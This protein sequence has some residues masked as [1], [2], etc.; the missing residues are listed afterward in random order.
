MKILAL[1]LGIII[2]H[3]PIEVLGGT[4]Y[5]E[6]TGHGKRIN[7]GLA[8]FVPNRTHIKDAA[9]A[10]DV[11]AVV[12][13]DLLF[14]RAFNLIEGGPAPLRGTVLFDIWK[15]QGAEVLVAAKVGRRIDNKCVL[16]GIIYNVSDG[17]I[18]FE[19]QLIEKSD[20]HRQLA[21]RWA[22]EVIMHFL[23]K[24]GVASSK[25][26][27]VNDMSG[28]KELYVVDYDGEN[29]KKITD[30]KSIVLFPEIS[31]DGQKILF[32][33][34]SAGRQILYLINPD[35][36]KRKTIS[37][38]RG[39]NSA[40][41]WS[42]DGQ[43]IVLTLSKDRGPDIY[44]INLSGEILKRLT[45]SRAINTAPSFSPDGS[46]VAYTSNIPGYPQIYVMDA[47]GSNVQRLTYTGMCDS[48]A[49][50]PN[51]EYIAF[52]KS[53]MGSGY[54]IYTIEV[55]TGLQRC[56]T[57]G[58]GSNENPS[59]SPDSRFIVFTTTRNGRRQLYVMGMDG[60][61]PQPVGR[62]IGGNSFTP[63]WGVSI[64]DSE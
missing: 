20:N 22:D 9:L 45:F 50:A 40:G 61:N 57:W 42:P 24:K 53:E 52:A 21:H 30:D 48:P 32:T 11:H 34:Y 51:G 54:N 38:Y 29:L 47:Y 4:V 46:R 2:S 19:K 55:A 56:L 62:S 5:L 15:E 41:A 25:I 14:T 3:M 37:S 39:L 33:S 1:F 60:S 12:Q 36:R 49:W 35:G 8:Q 26:A 16:K 31:P 28:S 17:Q 10:R 18:I 64:G 13:K 44:I 23:G 58:E 6:L 43:S 27:F 63:H 7:M 59:W